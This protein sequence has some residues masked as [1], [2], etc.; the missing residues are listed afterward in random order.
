MFSE[1]IYTRCGQGIDIL[2]DGRP[3]TGG[4]GKVYSC[5]PSLLKDGGTDL[6]LLF[7]AAQTP[8]SYDD[9]SFMDDAYL[10]F[11]P[12]KG[13]SFLVNFYPVH[14][15]PNAKG[16]Y[17]HRAGNFL[18]HVIV[19]DFTGFYPFE[20]FRDGNVWNAK[21]RGEAF[22]YENAP[23][24]LPERNDINDPAGQFGLKEIGTFIADGRR[25]ALMSAV[26]FLISQYGLPAEERK[27]L[28]V[29]D[30]SEEKIE[31]WIA[32]IEHAFSPRISASLPFA[33]RMDKFA[34]ANRYTV[35]R[36]GAFQ[37]QINLQDSNQ[38]LRY[39]A[40]VVG[41][42]ERDSA[43][44]RAARPLANSP[45]VLLDGREKK[46]MF[47]ADTS[48][49]YY[50]IITGF[51]GAH[52]SFCREFLQMIDIAKPSPDIYRLL[53][54]Y[55]AVCV[56]TAL[57]GAKD[58]GE[59]LAVLGNYELLPSSAL[60]NIYARVTAGI[61]LFLQEDLHSALQII[62]WL[63]SVSRAAGD[64]K[65]SESLAGHV[66]NVFAELVFIKPD[67]NGAHEFWRSIKDSEFAKSV[68]SYCVAPAT[69]KKNLGYFQRFEP[70]D[71]LTY[72]LV[73]LECAAFIGTVPT[74]DLT[75][76]AN[77]GL[78]L[79]FDFRDAD[80]ARKILKALG[81]I[82]VAGAQ[83]VLLSIAKGAEQGYA[84]F[85]VMLLIEHDGSIMAS[86]DSMAAFLKKLGA[87]GIG[88]LR[89]C[90]LKFRAQA[91]KSPAELGQMLRLLDSVPALGQND[92]AEILAL[93]DQKLSI[94][95][96]NSKAIA[97]AIQ[98]RLPHGTACPI[99]AHLAALAVLGDKK[100]RARFTE[101][102]DEL[103]QQ[104]FPSIND[105]DYIDALVEAIFKA[106]LESMEMCY[107][108]RLFYR[109]PAYIG[110]LVA[111]ILRKTSLRQA[112]E[113]EGLVLIAAKDKDRNL[114]D[115]LINECAALKQGERALA[116]L[117]DALDNLAAHEYF[118]REI[119]PK[120][121]EIIRSHKSQSL[122]GRIFG[123]R[124]SGDDVQKRKK[125]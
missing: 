88:H 41:V 98:D 23:A 19:G 66:C 3:I 43:N 6:Q 84:E 16:E 31:L 99:S 95:D 45:F 72:A 52:Q 36:M 86:D 4:G 83:S 20:L 121:I 44:A 42:D 29:R 110:T 113:W 78:R 48:N 75:S 108:I 87:G 68:A 104:G 111:A 2:K 97:N 5:T 106:K 65:A 24:S 57:P 9:P 117:S 46:A 11:V 102:Y 53:D 114:A 54:V 74:E 26:S 8:Q 51:D 94:A 15:D 62:K 18:N 103:I 13:N 63:Q 21:A 119:A 12:D 58:M 33:T 60:Q 30:E 55:F 105:G 118:L 112:E 115:A 22:Y 85:I 59:A 76:V 67:S 70:I 25:E 77:W 125:R 81:P 123:G 122:F 82:R 79:C 50:R 47:E 91:S 93:L 64:A 27:F 39:R 32:A 34:T 116:T 100:Q 56:S 71:K 61:P 92:Q 14:F 37:T 35:N 89:G 40:M 73:Y 90:V 80:S 109:A 101:I 69:L 49:R 28:V 1:L 38:K 124:L 120:S 10:Y 107:V 96:K 17:S 7:N